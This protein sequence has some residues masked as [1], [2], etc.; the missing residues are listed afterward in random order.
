MPAPIRKASSKLQVMFRVLSE[1]LLRH[2][3]LESQ[4]LI[5][6]GA[7]QLKN[8]LQFWNE[9]FILSNGFNAKRV[10]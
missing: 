5:E 2:A 3:F 4:N 7:K 1:I 10:M 9:E 6:N 8:K